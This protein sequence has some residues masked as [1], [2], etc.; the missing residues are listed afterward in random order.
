MRKLIKY[1]SLA[2]ASVF[3]LSSCND[4]EDLLKVN[5]STFIAPKIE[6]TNSDPI[7]LSEENATETAISFKWSA[8]DYGIATVPKYELQLDKK[9][10]NFKEPKSIATISETVYNITVKELNNVATT[11]GLIPGTA[12]DLEYRVI[13]SIG[14]HESEV[15]ISDVVSI[16]VTTYKPKGDPVLYLVGG[17]QSYYGKNNWNAGDGL[18]MR[19]IGD[20]TTKVFE[21]YVKVGQNDGIKFIG[22]TTDFNP[23]NYGTSNGAQNGQLENSG[24]SGDVKIAETEGDG[25]YYVQVDIDKLTY[26]YVKMNWG[27]I[28][29]ATPNGWDNETAL[30]YNFTD[31]VFELT[32]NL[33]SGELKFRS[34]N[35]GNK[36]YNEDWKF[37][38]GDSS[39]YTAY[40]SG[41]PNFKVSSKET[42]IKVKINYDG[43]T[44]LEGL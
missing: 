5:P 35:S 3:A 36:I 33:K 43:I 19:Y 1:I 16:N 12:E 7:I 17:V 4:D 32:T 38:I 39:P 30:N 2:C 18:K 26:K 6:I 23:D 25:L 42:T 40:D 20:G 41:G 31:N 24:S 27:I 8:A 34:K 14:T 10:N 21:A 11:L 37:N 13:S 15:L 44:E 28:G 29:D 22:Q 9:G